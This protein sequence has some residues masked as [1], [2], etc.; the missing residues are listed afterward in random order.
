[1]TEIDKNVNENED[2]VALNLRKNKITTL[3]Y[4]VYIFVLV[5][6]IYFFWSVFAQLVEDIRGEW[7]MKGLFSPS[8]LPNIVY[9]FTSK[10]GEEGGLLNK[11]DEINEQIDEMKQKIEKVKKEEEI[12]ARLN[13]GGKRNTI[14]TCLN[15]N[16][17][18]GVPEDLLPY[19]WLFRIY[20]LI[21]NLSFDKMEFNQKKILK[22]INDF[23]LRTISWEMNG[24][25]LAINFWSISVFNDEYNIYT[26]PLSITVRFE[27]EKMLMSFL[28]NLEERI[29]TKTHIFYKID[30]MNYN[31]VEYEEEQEININLNAYYIKDLPDEILLWNIFSWNTVL[32]WEVFPDSMIGD[33]GGDIAK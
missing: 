31:I 32:T 28:H 1:M 3:R 19:L 8:E 2:Q 7:A 13:D 23:L 29:N 20:L 9:N 18:E 26:L 30:A 17:C 16:E 6:I 33:V 21:G 4:K 22:N 11:I 12:I 27:N 10:R 5:V 25:L 14:I 15:T 24:E